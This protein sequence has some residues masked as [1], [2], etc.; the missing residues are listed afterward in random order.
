MKEYIVVV[1]ES[2]TFAIKAPSAAEAE[3]K[4]M[5]VSPDS[6]YSSDELSMLGTDFSIEVNEVRNDG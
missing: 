4:A 3:E 6:E 1:K 2:T 5:Y